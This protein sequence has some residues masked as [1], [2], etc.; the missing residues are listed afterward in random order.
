MSVCLCPAE[1]R[2]KARKD[3]VRRA[4]GPRSHLVRVQVHLR[5][6]YRSSELFNAV[7]WVTLRQLVGI[8]FG[9]VVGQFA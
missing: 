6:G 7:R 3:H 5:T 2:G 4:T 8:V 9:V 1:I